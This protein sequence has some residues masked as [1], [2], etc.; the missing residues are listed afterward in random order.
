M[1]QLDIDLFDDFLFFAF[2]S[3]LFG[4][5]DEDS[6]ENVIEMGAE[7]YVAHFYI[8]TKKKIEEQSKLVKLLFSSSV[9]KN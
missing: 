1:P 4:F 7:L 5:G 8:E 3:L 9:L 6:E 2:V